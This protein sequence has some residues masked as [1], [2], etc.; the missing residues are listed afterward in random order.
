[1]AG[2]KKHK[3]HYVSKYMPGYFGQVGFKRHRSIV[4]DDTTMNVGQ[5]SRNI[6][7]MVAQGLAT[8]S[9]G[10]YEIDMGKAG[11]TKLLGAGKAE[12]KFKVKVER[13]SEG[14]RKKIEAA[15][16]SVEAAEVEVK[17]KEPKKTPA[18]QVAQ[19][20]EKAKAKTAMK[21]ATKDAAAK[22]AEK[23]P[24]KKEAGD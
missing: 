11:Y 13:C 23:K 8:G 7:T 14:A 18:Q 21:A 15:G 24:K 12:A 2:S 4:T 17:E 16:G 6:E 5:L 19:K 10:S 9:K 20:V 3:W 1:M 22:K